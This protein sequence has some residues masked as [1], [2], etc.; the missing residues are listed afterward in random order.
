MGMTTPLRSIP[1]VDQNQADLYPTINAA[2]QLIES[3]FIRV[4]SMTTT[5]EPATPSESDAYIIPVNATGTSWAT[6]TANNIAIYN[7]GAWSEYPPIPG[8]ILGLAGAGPIYW[9]NVNSAWKTIGGVALPISDGSPLLANAAD[10]TKKARFDLSA[11]ATATSIVLTL[12]G[13]SGTLARLADI[14]AGVGSTDLAYDSTTTTGLTYGY[15]AGR[16][17]SSTSLLDVAAGTLTLP[18]SST[19][20]VE[21]DPSGTV[22]SNTTGWTA[23]SIPL[24]IVPTGASAVT[25][26]SITD[27]RAWLLVAGDMQ[28]DGSVAMT[29]DLNLGGHQIKNYAE[30]TATV[31]ATTTTTTL[32]LSTA[33]HFVVNMQANTTLAFSNIPATG[34]TGISIDFVQD[35]TGSRLL[36]LPAGTTTPGGAGITLSTAASARDRVVM[37]NGSGVW[38]AFMAGAGMA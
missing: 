21:V 1:E 12:P 7:G 33:R 5:A 23:G 18:A 25:T 11:L 24:S 26:G 9:D 37:D 3:L 17:R 35:A 31:A 8:Q 22:S 27:E 20:Y 13:A 6:F 2:L 10:N 32:D 38:N 34:V 15:K 36:T 28:S 19:N 4:L 30:R 14:P 16:V 29:A